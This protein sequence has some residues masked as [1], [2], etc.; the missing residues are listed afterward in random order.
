MSIFREYDIRGVADTDLTDA[1]AWGLGKTLA[2]LTLAA[3]DSKAY[4][5]RDVRLSSPRLAKAI[6]AGFEAGGVEV[7]ILEPGP[8]PLLYFAAHEA[9]SD[10][11][12]RT[13]VMVTGS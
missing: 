11:P 7:R 6:A 3:G 4:I 8:T 5:G 12:T 10:F 1:I 2:K 13:G 9:V